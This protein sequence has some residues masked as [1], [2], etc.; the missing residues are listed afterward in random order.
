M[1]E[2]TGVESDK[3]KAE[4]VGGRGRV[5]CVK[6]EGSRNVVRKVPRMLVP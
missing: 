5:V 1:C 6:L 3:A 4:L 2:R